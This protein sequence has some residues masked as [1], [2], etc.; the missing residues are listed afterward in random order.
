MNYEEYK[1]IS[2]YKLAKSG[3]QFEIE[4]V[5][6]GDNRAVT[7][8][9]VSGLDY[10]EGFER[11]PVEEV[12]KT[13]VDEI[14]DGKHTGSGT[15]TTFWIPEQNDRF[16][17]RDTFVGREYWI[18][19]KIAEGWPG[20]GIMVEVLEG[21]KFTGKGVTQAARGLI[22]VNASFLYTRAY[23]G[24]QVADTFGQDIAA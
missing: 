10:N 6:K 3:S 20:V 8:S 17:S 2:S 5:L 9:R 23:T 7:L 1:Q 19:K 14:A 21:V 13:G 24:Q 11:L 12:G 4:L 22:G 16:D 18:V 15:L